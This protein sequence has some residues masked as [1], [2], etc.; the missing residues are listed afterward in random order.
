MDEKK[1]IQ[2]LIDNCGAPAADEVIANLSALQ[3][4][5]AEGEDDAESWESDRSD[6]GRVTRP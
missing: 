5:P 3:K 1:K 4:Q 2:R 6:R